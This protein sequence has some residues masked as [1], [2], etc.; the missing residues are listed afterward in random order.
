MKDYK[1][2][3]CV[4]WSHRHHHHGYYFVNL[5]HFQTRLWV[6][7]IPCHLKVRLLT[8][9]QSHAWT[10]WHLSLRPGKSCYSWYIFFFVLCP[11]RDSC[12]LGPGQSSIFSVAVSN[13]SSSSVND[14]L[15]CAVPPRI[16]VYI[17]SWIQFNKTSLRTYSMAGLVLNGKNCCPHGGSSLL[18]KYRWY[19]QTI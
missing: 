6:S 5:A 14:A 8:H 12:P 3:V 4:R 2:A 1:L 15:V 13:F 9:F 16:K 19:K 10:H 18:R 11:F 7:L 17:N